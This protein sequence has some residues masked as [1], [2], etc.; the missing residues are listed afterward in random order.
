VD[1]NLLDRQGEGLIIMAIGDMNNDKHADIV[2]VNHQ[3]DHFTVHFYNPLTM[4][5]DASATWPI[6]LTSTD[7]KIQSIVISRDIA[8]FQQLFVFYTKGGK[9]AKATEMKIYRTMAYSN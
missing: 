9:S 5:Y 6:D 2:T 1:V 8:A 3:Q 4:E 7:T